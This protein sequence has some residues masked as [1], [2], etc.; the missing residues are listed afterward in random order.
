MRGEVTPWGQLMAATAISAI[1]L[2]IVYTTCQRFFTQGIVMT[3]IK[4]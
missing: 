1:P 3:G 4:G 2:T